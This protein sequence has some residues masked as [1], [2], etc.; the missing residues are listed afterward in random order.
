MSTT[1]TKTL[2]PLFM[3]LTLFVLHIIFLFRALNKP[4][5]ESFKLLLQNIFTSKR[6]SDA[7]KSFNSSTIIYLCRYCPWLLYMLF[8]SEQNMTLSW[9]GEFFNNLA[10]MFMLMRRSVAYMNEASTY[11]SWQKCVFVSIH[12]LQRRFC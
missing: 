10:K 11:L 2:P 4:W 5:E 8:F 3:L 7:Y 9:M 12:Q 6:P 1:R